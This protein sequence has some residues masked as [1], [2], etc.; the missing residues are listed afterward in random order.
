MFFHI[1]TSDVVILVLRESHRAAAPFLAL[2]G[3]FAV[4][5]SALGWPRA[6]PWE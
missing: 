5:W 2:F 4:A 3:G 1:S 6:L